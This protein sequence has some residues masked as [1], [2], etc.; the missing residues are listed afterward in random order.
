M[1][2]LHICD[3]NNSFCFISII[4]LF[5]ATSSLLFFQYSL[6]FYYDSSIKKSIFIYRFYDIRGFFFIV[7]PLKQNNYI[8]KKNPLMV[9]LSCYNAPFW[10]WKFLDSGRRSPFINFQKTSSLPG[11]RWE[12]EKSRTRSCKSQIISNTFLILCTQAT[13]DLKLRK[14]TLKES[15]VKKLPILE[16]IDRSYILWMNWRL[17]KSNAQSAAKKFPS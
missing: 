4:K 10:H 3:I 9:C 16:I 6:F 2:S 1:G 11:R 8:D 15:S 5:A 7:A 12:V 17:W 13:K 14:R